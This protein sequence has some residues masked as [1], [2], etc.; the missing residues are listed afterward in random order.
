MG[1]AS[2]GVQEQ[3]A[4]TPLADQI[5]NALEKNRSREQKGKR[6]NRQHEILRK[7]PK[8]FENEIKAF[9]SLGKED[10]PIEPTLAGEIFEE[11][12]RADTNICPKEET[13][14]ARLIRSLMKDP[15]IYGLEQQ[16]IGGARRNPDIA[17]I[18]EAGKIVGAVEVKAGP[19]SLRGLSQT[20]TFE[21]NLRILV[22]KLES[23]EP[24]ILQNH[25]L[26]VIVDNM[27]KLKVADKFKV[28]LAIP[29]GVY[30]KNDIGTIIKKKDFDTPESF[31]VA[32]EG[33][34]KCNLAISPFSREELGI[35]TVYVAEWLR[36]ENIGAKPIEMPTKS[37]NPAGKF[38]ETVN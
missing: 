3:I 13:Q 35:I 14:T 28:T 10:V 30:R 17:Q 25:G 31:E 16:G 19:I 2:V 6:Q 21:E 32:K 29:Y 1:E 20:E 4:K 27:H 23:I 7:L 9:A 8:D 22:D 26:S 38:P 18:N 15:G 36:K 33:L 34:G 11:L 24:I 5:W 12:V 37:N